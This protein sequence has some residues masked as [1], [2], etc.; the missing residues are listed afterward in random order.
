MA[1]DAHGYQKWS[2]HDVLKGLDCANVYI[3]GFII[4]TYKDMEEELLANHNLD[5]K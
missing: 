5:V 1:H 2:S 4:G 3:D